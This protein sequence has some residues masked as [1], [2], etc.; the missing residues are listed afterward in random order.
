MSEPTR[1]DFLKTGSLAA[2]MGTG[3]LQSVSARAYANGSDEIRIG[4]VGCGGRGTGA[5]AQA[6]LTDG[7]VK[8]VAMGDV[9]PEAIDNA[10]KSIEKEVA[11]K[12][13]AAVEV[14]ASRKFVG[15]DAY[16]QV[17]DSDIDLVV[18]ATPPGL[19]PWH[20]EYAVE[21][22]KHVFMEKPVAVDA[23]GVQRVLNA[24]RAAKEKG[25]KVGVGLQRHHQK[26]YVELID[27][28]H[29]G[30][31]G[32]VRL[33]RAYWNGGGVWEPRIT[34]DKAKSEMEYQVR[35]WYYY[36]W[37]CGDHIVEQHIH[38]VDV[39]NWVMKGYPVKCNG[40]GGREVRK[41]K[42]YG[43]I[44]DHHACEFTYEDGTVMLS[45]C[46]HIHNCWN[47]VSEHIHTTNGILNPGAG[48]VDL[49]AGNNPDRVTG[50]GNPYQ[51]E[52][53]HLFAA[54]RKGEEYSEADNGAMSTMTAILGRMCTYSG[55]EIKMSDALEKGLEITP[56]EFG[57]DVKPPVLPGPDGAYPIAIPGVT[58][59]MRS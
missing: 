19:R 49:F 46:R 23:P 43:E 31:F 16:K 57:W 15:W 33:I 36:N 47:S 27:R 41:D 44:Y 53:D 56:Q 52:H 14:D 5:A 50:G 58:Q 22:G 8:L 3:L 25:L 24:S 39:G 48:R 12:S 45:Q 30:E 34:P 40:M 26:P 9:F 28:L 21:K 38:N 54:I 1:R 11:G 55:K 4:L 7:K 20:F 42:K 29:Q 35:N 18:M 10:L 2:I 6:L 37:L 32:D 13:D 17:I 59:V 51:V